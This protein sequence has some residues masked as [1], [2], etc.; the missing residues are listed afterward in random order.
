MN[1]TTYDW[2]PYLYGAILFQGLFL[3][4]ILLTAKKGNPS[5]NRYLALIMF[6]FALATAE[7]V[8]AVSGLKE[9]W[10]HLLFVSSPFWFIL[11]PLYYFYARSFV[12][13]PIRF[14]AVHVLH[15]VPLVIV[16]IYLIPS[17][18][19]PAETKL[20]FI[21]EPDLIYDHL[22]TFLYSTFYYGQ[23]LVYLW[24]SIVT[25]RHSANR[26]LDGKWHLILYS[27][28][29]VYVSFSGIQS[30]YFFI[31]HEHLIQFR[32]W[33][34]PI[35]AIVIYSLAYTAMVKPEKLFIPTWKLLEQKEGRLS[36]PEM[37]NIIRRL[38]NLMTTEKL[39]LD[40]NLK[41]SDVAARL[42]ISVRALS[43]ALNVHAG[44][45]FNDYVNSYRIQEAKYQ[46]LDGK[47]KRETI[48][49]VAFKSGFSTKSSFN[50]IF[51]S[52]TGLTPTE[53]LQ[54]TQ[55]QAEHRTY[56]N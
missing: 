14:S 53:F 5:A 51:K 46:M 50:R 44:E 30:V 49:S 35:Y 39:Y 23:S 43:H 36:A 24:L 11:P 9:L 18:S 45:S 13:D 32:M 2:W 4:F 48:L 56:T 55:P 47:L 31:T 22:E 1:S 20:K 38:E 26:K 28:F 17:Y 37:E 34:I 16:I 42:G 8:A 41:Y 19:L 10:P 25:L 40:C 7:R 29:T 54:I 52:N 15:A 6:M 33:G 27:I 21:R 3:G 12:G